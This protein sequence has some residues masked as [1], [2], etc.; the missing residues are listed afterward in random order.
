MIILQKSES[1]KT[2]RFT[3]N[4]HLGFSTS[5][6]LWYSYSDVRFK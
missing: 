1:P 5:Y 6:S 4:T 2:K 3:W